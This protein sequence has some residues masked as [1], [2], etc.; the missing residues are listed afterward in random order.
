MVIALL[1]V[2]IIGLGG[3]FGVKKCRQIRSTRQKEPI[4]GSPMDF[5]VDETNNDDP[6]P[7][8]KHGDIPVSLIDEFESDR[9]DSHFEIG[10]PYESSV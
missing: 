4:P 5:P 2:S 6:K 10:Q 9:A 1:I 7:V 8:G 3:Y